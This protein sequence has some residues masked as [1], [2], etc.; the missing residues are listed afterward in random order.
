MVLIKWFFSSGLNWWST[1]KS[2]FLQNKYVCVQVQG[3][4]HKQLSC[5]LQWDNTKQVAVGIRC[6]TVIVT[7]AGS[8]VVIVLP[9]QTKKARNLLRNDSCLPGLIIDKPLLPKYCS[10]PQLRRIVNTINDNLKTPSTTLTAVQLHVINF[11]QQ[12]LSTQFRFTQ[13]QQ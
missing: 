1:S 9:C 5:S 3:S 8:I 2:D 4:S 11:M 10:S 7:A 12:L 6:V 13:P